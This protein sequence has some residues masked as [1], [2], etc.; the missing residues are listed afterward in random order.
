MK[1]HASQ[2]SLRPYTLLAYVKPNH[3]PGLLLLE[4]TKFVPPCSSLLRH[5]YRNILVSVPLTYVIQ[6][7]LLF[8]KKLPVDTFP[9]S[10]L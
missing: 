2:T 4:E 9:T 8:S 1:D 3:R 5:G 10:S 7:Y 6:M